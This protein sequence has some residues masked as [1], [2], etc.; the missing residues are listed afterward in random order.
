MRFARR[1]G[2]VST[3]G[4]WLTR[5]L[6]ARM[7]QPLVD[8]LY[9]HRW[10]RF[11]RWARA[12]GAAGLGDTQEGVPITRGPLEGYR[13]AFSDSMAMWI[14]GHES[15]VMTELLRLLRPGMVAFDVGAHVGYSVLAMAH[16]TGPS[17]H[18]VGFEPDPL[19]F[20]LL[21]RNIEINGLGSYVEARRVALGSTQSMGR[22]ER[23]E[24]SVLTQVQIDEGGEVD[25]S[26]L[27]AEVFERSTPVPDLILVD[28]EGM[29]LPVFHG[30]WRLL[31]EHAPIVICEDQ[32]CRSEVRDL[33]GQVGY[34]GRLVDIDH[35]LYAKS[36]SASP[37]SG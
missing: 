19:N 36:S 34:E 14:G 6:A 29:E 3:V 20:E 12:R 2:A 18:V 24:L 28:V 17:G 4:S 10:N 11:V 13:F 22:L 27:D 30:G 26:T 25:V 15:A 9:R 16:A 32:G 7:P 8:F 21:A 37:G 5:A 35:T 23:G 1:L 33:L 31:T